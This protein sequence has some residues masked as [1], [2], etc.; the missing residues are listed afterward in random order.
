M[1][2]SFPSIALGAAAL[3]SSISL[4]HAS[5]IPSD[6]P[7][8]QLLKTA[9]AH[10][11]SG[12]SSEALSYFDAAIARDPQNYLTLFKR[13]AAYL[14]LGRSAQAERDFNAVL[15]LKPDFEGALVQRAKIKSRNGDWDSAM[16]DYVAA[17]K[18]GSSE[19]DELEEARNAAGLA[20]EAEANGQW[21]ECVQQAGIAIR[22][23]GAVVSLRNLRVKCRFEKGDVVE[24]IGDLQHLA[25]LTGSTEKHAQISALT[26]YA[27]GETEKGLGLVR[28]CLQSDPDNKACRTMMKKEKALDKRMKE[29]NGYWEKGSYA[30]ATRLLIKSA[31][32]AG[33]IQDSKDEFE[34]LRKDGIIY[35]KAPNGLYNL[36]VERTCQAYMEVSRSADVN[37][38]QC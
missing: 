11:A 37:E 16:K 9:N 28:K 27:L 38:M 22:I 12:K 17:G 24:A 31:E 7:V 2:I 34:D 15:E 20:E 13:G 35:E 5:D 19:V 30:S 23:A 18:G 36:L 32:S 25:Q 33:L 8:S 1:H 3:L 29:L 10:L 6:V 21:D 26:F 14:S 4:V